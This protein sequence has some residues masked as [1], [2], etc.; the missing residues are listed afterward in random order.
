MP[1]TST[2]H[3]PLAPGNT[4]TLE[5]ARAH[6]VG[7]EPVVRPAKDAL[8]GSKLLQPPT[9]QDGHLVGQGPDVVQ[10]VGDV[11]DG[12]V[13][14]AH[15]APEQRPR[16][17]AGLRVQG[18]QGLVH[19][20]EP[21]LDHQG[22]GQGHA[23]L[24]PARQGGR[25]AVQDMADVQGLGHVPY[26]GLAARLVAVNLFQ[27]VFDVGEHVLVGQERIVLVHD[28]DAPLF[29]AGHP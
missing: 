22:S 14:L 4:P 17:L 21:R 25:L 11:Q 9:G 15:D 2:L 27:S 1:W 8:H 10:V 7:N 19:E 3:E 5:H 13:P 6:E 26:L 29:P 23:L 18:G 24:F 28:A 20:Q 12:Y 16:G